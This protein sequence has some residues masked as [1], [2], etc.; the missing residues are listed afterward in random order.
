LKDGA[1]SNYTST[2]RGWFEEHTGAGKPDLNFV[3]DG[4]VFQGN[5]DHLAFGGSN[6]F[7]DGSHHFA[8][9]TDAD[10]NP[11]FAVANDDSGPEPES[12]ATFDD[13]SNPVDGDYFFFKFFRLLFD[14]YG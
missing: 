13:A 5:G 7:S 11:A 6:G 4:G 3:W 8:A 10:T 12:A 1:T 14:G 2:G 9:F